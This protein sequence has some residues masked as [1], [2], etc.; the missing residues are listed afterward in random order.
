MT[1]Q[2]YLWNS[3]AYPSF[4]GDFQSCIKYNDLYNLLSTRSYSQILAFLLVNTG[5]IVLSR[6]F[7]Q[8]SYDL[9]HLDLKRCFKFDPY[10]PGFQI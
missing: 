3:F 5:V 4:P 6:N 1:F 9:L 2:K 7:L 10:V 8:S